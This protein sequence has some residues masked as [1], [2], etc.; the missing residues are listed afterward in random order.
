MKVQ[1]S[2]AYN[3]IWVVYLVPSLLE[4]ALV[5]VITLRLLVCVHCIPTGIHCVRTHGSLS[6]DC[7]HCPDKPRD[8]VL[9]FFST[10]T[11]WPQVLLG[12]Q[13]SK[14]PCFYGCFYGCLHGS[15]LQLARLGCF[16]HQ[17]RLQNVIKPSQ[18]QAPTH[19]PVGTWNGT[20]TSL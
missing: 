20:E 2:S 1:F 12:Q 17:V 9:A 13:Q 11:F 4:C 3:H 10:L 5:Y 7:V 15:W 18:L 16:G 6:V 19:V 14:W 8:G